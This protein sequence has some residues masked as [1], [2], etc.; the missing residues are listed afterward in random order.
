MNII[1]VLLLL[2]TSNMTPSQYNIKKTFEKNL[3]SIIVSVEIIPASEWKWN[4]NYPSNF[5]VN[6]PPNTQLIEKNVIYLNGHPRFTFNIQGQIKSIK[7][8]TV[9]GS[10]SLCTKIICK[11]WRHK[12]F[13]I[14]EKN[15]TKSL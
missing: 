1:T 12:K 15:E 3:K 2:A 11:A 7:E 14:G 6:L 9:D 13:R 4:K 10:F 5:F 8:I